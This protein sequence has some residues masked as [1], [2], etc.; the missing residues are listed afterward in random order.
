MSGCLLLAAVSFSYAQS[1]SPL[2]KTDTI[3]PAV[4][5]AQSNPTQ[6]TPGQAVTVLLK[7]RKIVRGTMALSPFDGY[8]TLDL[9]AFSQT[10]IAYKKIDQIF[11]GTYT[12]AEVAEQKS[13]TRYRKIRTKEPLSFSIHEKGLYGAVDFG[14]ITAGSDYASGSAGYMLQARA[15]YTFCPLLSVGGGIG[16]DNYGY[17]SPR[18]VPVYATVRGIIGKRRWTPYYSLDVGGGFAWMNDYEWGREVQYH[19]SQGGFMMQ[20][21]LGYQWNLEKTS[22]QMG[23]NY[24]TQQTSFAYSFT[25]DWQG[26]TF[27]VDEKRRLSRVGIVFGFTF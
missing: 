2:S 9:D 11:F 6:P 14:I 4:S 8:L 17:A 18:V 25:D 22:I 16:I 15:G 27:E 13:S 12:K 19:R 21:G 1:G 5:P 20:A 26:T 3:P 10:H 7:N 24:K 23:L